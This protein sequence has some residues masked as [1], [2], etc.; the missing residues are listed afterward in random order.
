[1]GRIWGAMRAERANVTGI[2]HDR[3]AQLDGGC[4]TL[5]QHKVESPKQLLFQRKLTHHKVGNPLIRAR[6]IAEVY[7]GPPNLEVGCWKLEV[8]QKISF[9]LRNQPTS[10]VRQFVRL[11]LIN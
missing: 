2:R 7:P 5:S 1:V 8:G 9:D 6:S 3:D 11:E 10:F 4:N